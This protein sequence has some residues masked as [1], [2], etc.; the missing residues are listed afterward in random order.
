[1]EK[2]TSRKKV[3]L[4]GAMGSGKSALSRRLAAKYGATVFDTDAEFTR[5]YG[6]INAFFGAYGEAEFRAREQQIIIEAAYSDADVVATGGGAVLSRKGMNALRRTRDIV[7]LTARTET[8]K[9]RVMRSDRPLKA[10][11]DKIMAMRKSLYEM[12]A[13]YTVSSE[14]SAID[15]FERALAVPRGNRFDAVLCDAD[16][17][18]LDFNR[19]MRYAVVKA[20]RELGISKSDDEIINKYAEVTRIIWGRLERGEITRA[21]LDNTRFRL[22]GEMLGET[23]DYGRMNDTYI[24][25]MRGTRFVIDGAIEL[26]NALRSRGIK[27]YI[28]TNSF[29]RVACERLKAIADYADGAFISEEVGFDKPRPEF[30]ERVLSAIG[31]PDKSRTLVFGDSETSDIAGGRNSGLCTCLYGTRTDTAA[32]FSVKRLDELLDIV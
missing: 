9:A 25:Y 19:A 18:L 11:F 27:V 15:E 32:D 21:E 30:F 17:T 4:I 22:L 24:A 29:T 26:L 2:I 20:A 31:N 5:R 16:D 1:M 7:Y 6:E 12:Y 8:L 13:D 14:V 10:D 23:F 3:A 28:I